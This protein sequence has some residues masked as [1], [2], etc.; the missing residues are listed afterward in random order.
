[1]KKCPKCGTSDKYSIIC[2]G[3]DYTKP[4]LYWLFTD[5][6]VGAVLI[7]APILVII[8]SLIK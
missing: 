7:F 6:W 5:G 1:M 4:F 2:S 8:Y 3:C